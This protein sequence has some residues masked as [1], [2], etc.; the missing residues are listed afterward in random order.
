[1]TVI[2]I[3]GATIHRNGSGAPPPHLPYANNAPPRVGARAVTGGRSP[4]GLRSTD[5]RNEPSI[6]NGVLVCS[7]LTNHRPS[8]RR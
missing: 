1:M 8:M 6:S 5:A 4:Y 2:A 7:W 3:A